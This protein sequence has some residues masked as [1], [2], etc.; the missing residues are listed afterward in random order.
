MNLKDRKLRNDI[1]LVIVIKL[2]L[3]V[4]LWWLFFRG[5]DVSVDDAAAAAHL[6]SSPTPHISIN[7]EPHA[8]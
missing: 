3:I 2:M 5:A 6:L 1:A 7:G 8:Q 4:A